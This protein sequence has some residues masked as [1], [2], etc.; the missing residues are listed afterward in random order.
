MPT[1][2]FQR[3]SLRLEK[4]KLQQDKRKSEQDRKQHRERINLENKR[5]R[6]ERQ[7]NSLAIVQ[8][9]Q[10]HIENISLLKRVKNAEWIR[11]IVTTC[12]AIA[13]LIISILTLAGVRLDLLLCL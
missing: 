1:N 9:Q 12:I 10:Q 5:A 2:K 4:Q 3:E 11:W 6:E 7:S 8:S 13:A